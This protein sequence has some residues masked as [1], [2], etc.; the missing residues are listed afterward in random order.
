[1]FSKKEGK[2]NKKTPEYPNKLKRNGYLYIFDFQS[3]IMV[4]N[5]STTPIRK[6]CFL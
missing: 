2:N 1:M 4:F 3:I 6:Y 5:H